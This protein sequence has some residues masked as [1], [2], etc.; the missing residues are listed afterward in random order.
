MRLPGTGMNL[1]DA[2]G[3][4]LQ[5]QLSIGTSPPIIFI[6]DYSSVSATVSAMK[7]GA[8]EFLTKPVDLAALA[9]AVET[10][11]AHDRRER[12][13]YARR[14]KLQERLRSLT[15]RQREVF[16]LVVGGLLNKEAAAIFDISEVTLQIHRSQIMRK[17]AADSFAELVRMAVML[18]I[19]HWRDTSTYQ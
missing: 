18:H 9:A 7:V 10:A 11:L 6:S 8:M 4:E 13:R 12:Q 19:P 5:Q 15:P 14:A 17:M 16:P 1:A 3:L 2:N